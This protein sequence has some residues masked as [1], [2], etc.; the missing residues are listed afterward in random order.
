MGDY[1]NWNS[2]CK[3][4]WQSAFT[5]KLIDGQTSFGYTQNLDFQTFI[6]KNLMPWVEPKPDI[7]YGVED[8]V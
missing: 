3:Y 2:V 4:Q 5:A 1:D 8:N 6:D 7:L